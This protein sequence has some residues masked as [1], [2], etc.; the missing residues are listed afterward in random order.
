[1][2]WYQK[3]MRFAPR[4]GP[5]HLMRHMGRDGRA[6][7]FRPIWWPAAGVL[8]RSCTSSSETMPSAG[9]LAGCDISCASGISRRNLCPHHLLKT[10]VLGGQPV[11]PFLHFFYRGRPD[12]LRLSL[13]N[14]RTAGLGGCVEA[15]KATSTVSQLQR[16]HWR[17]LHCGSWM[18]QVAV[19]LPPSGSVPTH[20]PGAAPARNIQEEDVLPIVVPV[21]SDLKSESFKSRCFFLFFGLVSV[22][23]CLFS[24]S[25][26][27]FS[28]V[29]FC[30][31]VF[32]VTV[33]HIAAY[34]KCVLCG[35]TE[36]I[37]WWTLRV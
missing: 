2:Q 23:S 31:T 1:M 6:I 24:L 27:F 12:P 34:P 35:S 11:L 32:C 21:K 33:R 26:Y 20:S 18:Q 16:Q 5:L 29:F 15:M 8:R 22:D 9:K 19:P 30:C 14:I 3:E 7:L 13:S 25:T 4:L 36:K 10:S 28:L 37:I 17:A